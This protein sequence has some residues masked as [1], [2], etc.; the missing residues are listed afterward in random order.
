MCVMGISSK[1]CC[2][3]SQVARGG[4]ILRGLVNLDNQFSISGCGKDYIAP[5]PQSKSIP[6][7]SK[8]MS[9]QLKYIPH[10][11][12]GAELELLETQA[13]KLRRSILRRRNSRDEEIIVSHYENVLVNLEHQ[14][15]QLQRQRD[16]EEPQIQGQQDR[17]V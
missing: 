9:A 11:W 2:M 5:A 16:V 6:P 7:Q 14:I 8:P 4:N 12:V 3:E 15:T 13:N 1:L 17:E 10:E